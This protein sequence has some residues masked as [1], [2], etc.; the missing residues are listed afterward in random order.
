MCSANIGYQQSGISNK[1]SIPGKPPM[2]QTHYGFA[3]C[4]SRKWLRHRQHF[5]F[6]FHITSS[7]RFRTQQ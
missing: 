6:F 3:I 1:E 5:Y 2:S 7:L 4:N